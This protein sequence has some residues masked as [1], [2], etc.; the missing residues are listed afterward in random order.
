MTTLPLVVAH[1]GASG[2]APENTFAAFD[3]AIALDCPDIELDVWVSKDGVPVVMHDETLDRTTGAH[4]PVAGLTIAELRALDAGAWFGPAFSGEHVPSL[5]EVLARSVGKARFTVEIKA[6]GVGLEAKVLGLLTRYGMRSSASLCSFHPQVIAE[7]EPVAGSV[8]VWFNV[9]ALT[10]QAI[11]E[12]LRLRASGV[13]AP[14]DTV[15]MELAA[16]AR[17]RGLQ[18]AAWGVDSEPDVRRAVEC[19]L[20]RVI[21]DRPDAVGAWLGQLSPLPL[22]EG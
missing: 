22:G 18:T 19:G 11:V 2:Y 10:S 7:L 16:E 6:A 17:D 15:T 5:E 14:I 9:P 20:G 8:P 13:A 4:G 3:R 1:R 21:C 12:T